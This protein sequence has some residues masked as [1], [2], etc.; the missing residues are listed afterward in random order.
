MHSGGQFPHGLAHQ[1]TPAQ[2]VAHLCELRQQP[3]K[4]GRYGDDVN[5]DANGSHLALTN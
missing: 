3:N 5:M 1:Q 2:S 4:R